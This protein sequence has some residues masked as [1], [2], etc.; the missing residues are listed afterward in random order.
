MFRGKLSKI[1]FYIYIFRSSV[2]FVNVRFLP[3][4]VLYLEALFTL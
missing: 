4:N 3:V 2:Y 1:Q